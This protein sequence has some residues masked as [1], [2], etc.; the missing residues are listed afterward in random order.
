MQRKKLSITFLAI[1][2]LQ[3]VHLMQRKKIFI[4]TEA[5]IIWKSFV[6]TS[7]SM[8]ENS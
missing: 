4:V 3:I 1:H 2:Y 8:N 5:K 6:G 7:E